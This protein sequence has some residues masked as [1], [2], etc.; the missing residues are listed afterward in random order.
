MSTT[1]K[2][3]FLANP[4]YWPA[5]LGLGTL[6]L[7]TRLPHRWQIGFGRGLGML[8]Y[9]LPTKLTDITSTNIKLCFPELTDQ[10]RKQLV[11]KSFASLGIGL[12]EAAMA[13]WLPEKKLNCL[14]E[15]RGYE[16]VEQALAKGK[17]IILLGPHYTCLEIMGRVLGMRYAFAV[18]YAPH[19]KRL[20]AYIHE[21]FRQQ[22]YINYIPRHRVRQLLRALNNNMAIWYAYD[23]DGGK[24]R[25]VFAPFFGIQTASL[26]SVSRIVRMSGAAVIPISFERRDGDF[27]YEVVLSPPIENFPSKD[28]VEDATRLNAILEQAIRERPDQYVWQYKRF[29][30]R[31]Q[32]EARFY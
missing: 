32:G 23:V 10:E 19:K 16:H 25:S 7:V 8:L 15:L 11:K 26:T 28:P 22:H 9:Y 1:N 6:W 2:G 24:K 14:V 12:V 4:L 29:K 13:W 17:G 18:M 31:P 30:T 3:L 21:R 20:I 5:W 27:K